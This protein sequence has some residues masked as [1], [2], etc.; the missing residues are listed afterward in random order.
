MNI[1]ATKTDILMKRL[2][3]LTDEESEFL[4]SKANF[5]N[6]TSMDINKIKDYFV[7]KDFTV[8]IYKF[9]EF[10]LCLDYKGVCILYQTSEAPG[11]F[12]KRYIEDMVYFLEKQ[13]AITLPS[14]K[15]LLAHHNK[16]FMEF[17]R[18]GFSDESLKTVKCWCYGS[19]VDAKNFNGG[20]PVVIKQASS[21]GGE[22]VF[23]ATSRKEFTRKVKKAGKI[24]IADSVSGI[25]NSY[26]KRQAK[27]II[28]Y[29]SPEK[30]K[31]LKYDIT[32]LSTSLIIQ[33][34]I[35][36]LSGDY[37]IL[38]FGGKY[39][40][41]YR[42][43]RQHDFRASG[44]GSFFPVPEKEHE[45]LLN[46]ARKLAGEIDFPI[47]GMDIGFDGNNY[48]LLEFQVIHIG[49]SALHRSKYWHEYTNGKWVKYDGLSNLEEEFSR[50]IHKYIESKA[51]RI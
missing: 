39:Y 50:A 10:N 35:P 6:F 47:I 13:G 21:S 29:F 25:F 30:S 2:I 41:M 38:F 23:L 14:H 44:S 5:R 11:S 3:I 15:L 16:I 27:K 1:G 26:I 32:P 12:Y 45:G 8:E 36:G 4:I 48:H 33:T 51:Q 34:F 37:K 28:L 22:G 18:S 9:S 24:V 40:M 17:W 31:Y 46:F 20:F 7:S 19:W 43:N 49:T 42:K